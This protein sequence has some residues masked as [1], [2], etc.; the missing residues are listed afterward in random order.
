MNPIRRDER[1]FGARQ[2]RNGG[3][4]NVTITGEPVS[5]ARANCTNES[6]RKLRKRASF[7][8]A[9]PLFFFPLSSR[10]NDTE[11]HGAPRRPEGARAGGGGTELLKGRDEK[12]RGKIAL[13]RHSILGGVSV[14][15]R[16]SRARFILSPDSYAGERA[17]GPSVKKSAL[18]R[19]QILP[20][21]L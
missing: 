5:G 6:H 17:R 13:L 12:Q 3:G 9:S 2:N 10:R 7:S 20:D 4:L 21:Y 15:K 1:Q 8:K 14:N 18:S 11:F 16:R 19:G